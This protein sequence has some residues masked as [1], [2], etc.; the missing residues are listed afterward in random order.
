MSPQELIRQIQADVLDQNISVVSLLQKC[1]ILAAKLEEK[2]FSEWIERE[3]TGYPSKEKPPSY[4]IIKTLLMGHF[5]GIGGRVKNAKI[6]LD[7]F[8]E[9]FHKQ[10]QYF[11]VLNSVASIEESVRKGEDK[12]EIVPIELQMFI[13]EKL[14]SEM[15]CIQA[16]R[17]ISLERF[18][19]LITTVRNNVLNFVLRVEEKVPVSTESA[20]SSGIKQ[21]KQRSPRSATKAS[22]ITINT[23]N[24]TVQNLTTGSENVTQ[25]ATYHEGRSE[26]I[27]DK[28]RQVISE[29]NYNNE[30]ISDLIEKINQMKTTQ[31]TPAFT[32]IYQRFIG[33]IAD[34]MQVF[35]VIAPLLPQLSAFLPK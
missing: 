32:E 26:E 35:S 4:R 29:V 11:Y 10:L 17:Y 8:P 31:S 13:G 27:F 12:M 1:K 6:P 20:K 18:V 5:A 15:S 28:L 19:E 30:V 9:E 3:L 23:I 22:N 14:F 33:T 2:E 24:G 21:K 25:N 16:Y 34:H 7:I